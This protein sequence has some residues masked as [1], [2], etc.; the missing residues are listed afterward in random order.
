MQDFFW[1]WYLEGLVPSVLPGPVFLFP[2]WW[3]QLKSPLHVHASPDPLTWQV[4]P[5]LSKFLTPSEQLL[6]TPPP[7]LQGLHCAVPKDKDAVLP[8]LSAA[9]ASLLGG[10]SSWTRQLDLQAPA[11]YS[12][13]PKKEMVMTRMLYLE[14]NDMT[15]VHHIKGINY[16]RLLSMKGPKKNYFALKYFP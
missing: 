11:S 9:F 7:V 16:I 12:D 10:R 8:N 3:Q 2:P 15:K 13:L 6:L 5:W 14:E 4:W 1:S